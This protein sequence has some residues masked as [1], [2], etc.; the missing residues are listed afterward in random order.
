MGV[1]RSDR[2]LRAAAAGERVHGMQI[3]LASRRDAGAIASILLAAFR[4]FEPLYSIGG[5][6][7]TTLSSAEIA[8]RW[9]EGPTWI[10][11]AEGKV[12]G[13]VSAVDR[14]DETYVRSMAVMPSA[15]GRGVATRLL[16]TVEQF[17][18]DRGASRLALTTTPFLTAAI[19]L[20]ERVGFVRQSQRLE[21]HGTPLF[22]M[23]KPLTPPSS[24]ASRA[25]SRGKSARRPLDG[26]VAVVAGATRGAG[27]GIARGLGEAGA[28]VYCTG[29]SI[30]GQRSPY[31][32]PE[33]IDETAAMVNT[34]GG[35]AIAVRVD[36]TVEAEVQALFTRVI[37]ER[38]R[39]DILVDSVAGEEPLMGH[40]GSFWTVDPEHADV[41]LKQALV[42]HII[43]GKHAAPLM[44]KR[45]RGLIVEVVENDLLMA[46]G[47]PFSQSIK[48]A[49]KGLALNWAAELKPHGVS[50]IAITPGFLRSEAMLEHFGV[51]EKNWRKGGKKDRNFLESESPLFIGRVVAALAADPNQLRFTG[52]LLSS[53]EV[54]RERGL[55]DYD[56]R[57]PDWGRHSID[58]SVLPPWLIENFRVGTELQ[59]EW[60]TTL[61]KRTEAFLEK[62]PAARRP[63]TKKK[64]RKTAKR[65]RVS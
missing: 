54:A 9:A 52:Q 19:Q 50:A 25:P 31:K 47:N 5:F 12:V 65:R 63:R 60:L 14:G 36:H 17:A 27:R 28:V 42:S 44:I 24:R 30:T 16:E 32:R 34:A 64:N 18:V 20:Y 39:L 58:F 33:T 7:A 29:R 2:A 45:G 1:A 4:D 37:R 61:A 3:R 41:I 38:G 35:T 48:L 13:T 22:A 26:Q 43:T 6:S 59:L 23:V 15:R 40:W 8:A 55:E 11:I 56:G 21:L 49:L 57:R 46:G 62:L 51:T 10:A 53:W